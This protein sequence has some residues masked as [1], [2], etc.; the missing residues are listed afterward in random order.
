VRQLLFH[1]LLLSECL[2]DMPWDDLRHIMM[3]VALLSA[4]LEDRPVKYDAGVGGEW[5]IESC[6][7]L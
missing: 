6:A 2:D 1:L 7:L 3:A 4:S 5:Q